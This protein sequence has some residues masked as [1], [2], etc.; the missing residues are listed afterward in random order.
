MIKEKRYSMKL[1]RRLE[2]GAL[3]KVDVCNPGRKQEWMCESISVLIGIGDDNTAELIMS[4]EAWEAFINGEKIHIN[5]H[6]TTK[7]L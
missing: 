5:T 1:G 7:K 6:T 4:K 2:I 3:S